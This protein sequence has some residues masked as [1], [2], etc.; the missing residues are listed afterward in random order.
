MKKLLSISL[1]SLLALPAMAQGDLLVGKTIATLGEAKTWTGPKTVDGVETTVTYT[2]ETEKL[3]KLVQENRNTDDVFLFPERNND[4][5]TYNT[6]DNIAIGIQG[7][8]VDMGSSQTVASVYST[9]Q[10][11]AANAYNIYLLN[12]VPTL[13]NL[14]NPVYT[15]E[16]LDQYSENTAELPAN[17]KGRYLVFEPTDATNYVWGVK[18][19]SI[20]AYGDVT[21][22]TELAVSEAS[23]P[24]N[25]ST[26]VTVTPVNVI[27][28]ALDIT[29]VSNLT[30]TC[31]DSSA[32]KISADGQDDGTFS[33]EG[34]TVGTY[35]L[36]ATATYNGETVTGEAPIYVT[37]D[38]KSET[39]I[40]AGKKVYYRWSEKKDDTDNKGEN[41]TD[42]D[43]ETYYEY[44]GDWG[45]GDG[46]IVIDLGEENDHVVDAIEVYFSDNEVNANT[47]NNTFKLSFGTSDAELPT[48]DK[49]WSPGENW[50]TTGNLN[51]MQGAYVSYIVPQEEKNAIRYVAYFD[52]NNPEGKPMIGQI[53]VA[54][55]EI[56]EAPEAKEVT[57]SADF[58]YVSTG[59]KVTFTPIVIDQYGATMTDAPVV[60]YVNDN[61]IEGLE[62]TP[63]TVGN[64]SI[65]A[66]SGEL[67][68]EPIVLHVI[69]DGDKTLNGDNAENEILY[70]ASKGGVGLENN[71]F[72]QET[73]WA[74]EEMG[75]PLVI[76]FD[77]PVNLDLLKL[78]WE[79]ACP[80][81]YTISVTRQ[82]TRAGE[83]DEEVIMEVENRGFVN[84]VNPVDRIYNDAT[85]DGTTTLSGSNAICANNLTNIK[86]LIIT[87]TEKDHNYPLRLFG[88]DAIGTQASVDQ[89]G[90]DS[91]V[92]PLDAQVV[93]VVTLQGVVVKRNVNASDALTNLPK[94]IYIIGGK[95]VVVK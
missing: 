27:G 93:D 84:G 54:G 53:Y 58:D 23:I 24:A 31:S 29:S 35:T 30:L 59:E 36:T 60:V 47:G 34:I 1:L 76:V 52:T 32:V 25:S 75:T 86:S 65:V 49:A 6:E 67:V 50:I 71:P 15:A 11:A 13:S 5:D 89:S 55:S 42:N 39:N 44:N 37:F 69:A 74:N 51:K 72:T 26:T 77:A 62:Y 3:A 18:I 12:E 79:A 68:S 2:F 56:T 9:W 70:S 38:W 80:S 87:P 61:A 48:E 43:N 7:F 21:S 28:D 82:A 92:N 41:V 14:G 17:S 83:D 4:A 64:L 81:H 91:A 94:G 63:E 19:R 73:S 22:V 66:K 88:I 45:G 46:W 40:A 90:I 95:K 20:S 33:V 57:I 78:R 16:G 10:G 85:G 8:Y